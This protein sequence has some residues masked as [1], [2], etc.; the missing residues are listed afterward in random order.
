[1]IHAIQPANTIRFGVNPAKQ[2]KK[3][4]AKKKQAEKIRQNKEALLN[5]A[6]SQFNRAA[7]T[8]SIAISGLLCNGQT[9]FA[10][11]T[12]ALI[13]G[14]GLVLRRFNKPL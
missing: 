12:A 4:Y 7:I 14:T 6:N 11:I 9:T 3:N 10:V 1:M 8:G 2:N 13:V 5:K